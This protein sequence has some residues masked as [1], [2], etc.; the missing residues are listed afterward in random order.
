VQLLKILDQ[1]YFAAP[2]HTIPEAMKFRQQDNQGTKVFTV[3]YDMKQVEIVMLS[4][5]VL[6][7]KRWRPWSGSSTNISEGA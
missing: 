3:D 4:S 2:A 7:I 5:R 6:T 1:A